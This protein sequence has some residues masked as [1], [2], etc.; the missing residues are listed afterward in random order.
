MR[1]NP[2]DP[3]SL[4][5][6]SKMSENSSSP[7]GSAAPSVDFTTIVLSLRHVALGALGLLEEGEEMV[8]VDRAA[9]RMQIDMLDVLKEKTA[10]NLSVDEERLITSVLYELRVAFVQS[11][12][13]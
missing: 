11:A 3:I 8:G 9:A 5:K 4:P 7:R 6:V 12:Q 2:W 10:G 13:K 1:S